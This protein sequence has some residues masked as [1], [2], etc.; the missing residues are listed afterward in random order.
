LICCFCFFLA[1]DIFLFKEKREN[2]IQKEKR[3]G[4]EENGKKNQSLEQTKHLCLYS[5]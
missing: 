1:Q 4:K 5:S 2:E 3:K